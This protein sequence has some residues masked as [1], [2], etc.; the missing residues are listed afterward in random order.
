LRLIVNWVNHGVNTI[1]HYYKGETDLSIDDC[2]L[3]GCLVEHMVPPVIGKL[4]TN[5]VSN[6][7]P[8]YTQWH[9]VFAAQL[10]YQLLNDIHNFTNFFNSALASKMNSVYISSGANSHHRVSNNV[11]HASHSE[12]K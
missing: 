5:I 11:L 9:V 2:N 7:H 3:R 1:T 6:L 8:Q 12:V 10:S 4:I